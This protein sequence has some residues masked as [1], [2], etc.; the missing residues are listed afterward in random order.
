[1]SQAENV[2]LEIKC[3][4]QVPLAKKHPILRVNILQATG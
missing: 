2:I 4:K 1:M 3:L